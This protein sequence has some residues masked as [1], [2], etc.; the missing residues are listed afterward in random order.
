MDGVQL[1]ASKGVE[2]EQEI[3]EAE[4]SFICDKIR[5][6]QEKVRPFCVFPPVYDFACKITSHFLYFLCIKCSHVVIVVITY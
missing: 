5:Q 1:E 2:F 6:L 3:L 4:Y